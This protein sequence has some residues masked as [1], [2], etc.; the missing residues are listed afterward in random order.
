MKEPSI[1]DLDA[2]I[3]LFQL[4]RRVGRQPGEI[5]LCSWQ[6]LLSLFRRLAGAG[7]GPFSKGRLDQILCLAIRSGRVGFGAWPVQPLGVVTI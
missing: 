2:S 7:I 5:Q 6:V 4:Y 1:R 3:G